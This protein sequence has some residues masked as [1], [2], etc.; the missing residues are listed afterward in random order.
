MSMGT[1]VIKGHVYFI[2]PILQKIKAAS[3]SRH[4]PN[5]LIL[6]LDLFQD[7][8]DIVQFA[9]NRNADPYEDPGH[10]AHYFSH[11]RGL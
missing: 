3:L 6:V 10:S 2:P 7:I 8:Q 1:V 5:S 9:P 11:G 4:V